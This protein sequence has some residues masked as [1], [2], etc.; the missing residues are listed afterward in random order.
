MQMIAMT[1]KVVPAEVALD[2]DGDESFCVSDSSREI[3][4]WTFV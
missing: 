4:I 2:D 1:A 3:K